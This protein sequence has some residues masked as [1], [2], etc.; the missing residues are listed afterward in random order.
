MSSSLREERDQAFAAL[1][2][3]VEL[4]VHARVPS[5]PTLRRSSA[6]GDRRRALPRVR[7]A[8]D[9]L[10][11]PR[12]C[13]TTKRQLEGPRGR[14][15]RGR[16]GPPAAVPLRLNAFVSFCT[17][18]PPFL[19]FPRFP[20]AS[21]Q[22]N[23]LVDEIPALRAKLVPWEHDVYLPLVLD[24]YAPPGA[25]AEAPTAQPPARPPSSSFGDDSGARPSATAH[26][27]LLERWTMRYAPVADVALR[28]AALHAQYVTSLA[29]LL[30]SLCCRLRLMPSYALVRRAAHASAA[31]GGI[32]A[33]SGDAGLT[34]DIRRGALSADGAAGFAAPATCLRLR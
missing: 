8:R 29:I 2:L 15:A 5:I 3:A 9:H 32:G 20:P 24:V 4:I 17:A 22:F 12:G 14:F 27:A 30:R 34:C 16:D 18:A 23:L 19:W 11:H 21:R 25:P 28:A 1:V 7:A 31:S 6:S 26:G 13:T 10:H 33:A